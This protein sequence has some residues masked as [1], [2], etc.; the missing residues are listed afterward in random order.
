MFVGPSLAP[1][2]LGAS[3]DKLLADLEYAGFLFENLV[4]RDLRVLAQ[5]LGGRLSHARTSDNYEVDA[6]ME[7]RDG[8]WAV[9][10]VKLGHSWVDAGAESLKKFANTVDITKAGE[11]AALVVVVPDGFAYRRPDGVD[12]VPLSALGA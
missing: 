6:I 5:P 1:A 10:E 7:L 3:P 11:P 9:F 4:V 8:T 12:V 2:V